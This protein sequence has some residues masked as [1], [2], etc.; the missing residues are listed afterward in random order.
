ML[1][2][3]EVGLRALNPVLASQLEEGIALLAF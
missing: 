2:Q 1:H 3:W